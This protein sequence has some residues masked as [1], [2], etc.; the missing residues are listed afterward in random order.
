MPDEVMHLITFDKCHNHDT[1]KYLKLIC[2][3][4]GTKSSRIDG[5]VRADYIS[6]PPF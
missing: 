2:G 4:F 1:S 6:L 5:A 3:V